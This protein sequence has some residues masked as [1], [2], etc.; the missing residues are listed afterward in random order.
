MNNY[1][2]LLIDEANQ[3]S[4]LKA[5]GLVGLSPA[6]FDSRSPIFMAELKK[7]GVIKQKVFSFYL[8]NYLKELRNKN[9]EFFE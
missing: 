7:N 4:N 8:T 6:G 1:T 5:S 3:L 2:F 9:L